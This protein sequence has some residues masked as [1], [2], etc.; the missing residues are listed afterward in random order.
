VRPDLDSWLDRPVVR[1]HHR[2]EANVEPAA[3]WAAARSIRLADTRALGRLIRLRIPGLSSAAAFDDLFRSPPFIVLYA[4]DGALVSGLVGRIWT[5]QRDYP[6]LAE[7]D[8]FRR[9]MAPG[10]VRVLF[11]TWV[12]PVNPRITA[13]VSE[14]RVAAVDRRARL[15][16]AVVR[17]LIATSHNLIGSDGIDIAIKRARRMSKTAEAG[18]GVGQC[19]SGITR[20]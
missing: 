6:T 15:G 19:G 10:T 9:W 4:D 13:L 1:I 20:G 8:E 5:L 7:P 2:R 11:A 12:E 16:L 17:P 14:T 18:A 3:L